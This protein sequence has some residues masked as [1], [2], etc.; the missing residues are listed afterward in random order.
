[1]IQ[2]VLIEPE[3][4]SILQPLSITRCVWEIR[5]GYF[6]NIERWQHCLRDV[7]IG[8]YTSRK[9]HLASFLHRS[10]NS[11]VAKMQPLPT[12][13]ILGNAVVSP[14]EMRRLVGIAQSSTTAFSVF[15]GN[16]CIGSYIPVSTA[17]PEE[18]YQQLQVIDEPERINIL[19]TVVH[20]LWDVFPLLKHCISWDAE[21]LPQQRSSI[22][23][24]VAID[25]TE[26]PVLLGEGTV[27]EPFVV[28]K[29]PVALGANSVV[30]SFSTLSC[31]A[32]GRS[33]KLA[34]EI[35]E[36]V[37]Q[38]YCNKQHEG[39]VGN[40][41][42]CA[43]VNLGAG[44]TTSNL[45]NTYS[46]VHVVVH[47]TKVDSH[48]TFLGSLLGEHTR[49]AINTSLGTGTHI[50]IHTMIAVAGF[51][52]KTIASYTFITETG[53]I[54]KYRLDKALEVA[55][56]AMLRRNIELDEYTEAV[57]RVTYE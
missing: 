4:V 47:G 27:V 19:G 29:G 1:M 38:E 33:C 55:R 13:M 17:T 36:S 18:Y 24:T 25:E 54:T 53:G 8:V 11:P 6:T 52:P 26:G 31:T 34:G 50:G 51:A 46:T 2:V 7:A 16:E 15:I 35:S 23:S 49:T 10:S 57:Y 56:I 45:K 21:L 40:S 43:W 30:K 5:T 44:T 9:E 12:L 3:D 28:L 39:F 32:A 37:F 42:L 20:H 48:R 41:Y 14:E 22:H